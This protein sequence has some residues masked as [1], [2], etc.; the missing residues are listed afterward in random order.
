MFRGVAYEIGLEPIGIDSTAK[1]AMFGV[2]AI[3]A[4]AEPVRRLLIAS[5]LVT[6]LG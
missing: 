4:S 5:S 2:G 1:G 6:G 3:G